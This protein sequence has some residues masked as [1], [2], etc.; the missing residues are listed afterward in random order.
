[1]NYTGLACQPVEMY[2]DQQKHIPIKRKPEAGLDHYQT[3]SG[4]YSKSMA[5][6]KEVR[7]LTVYSKVQNRKTDL[8]FVQC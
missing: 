8:Q 5:Q 6:L 2:D 3:V 4:P 1:M 7:V